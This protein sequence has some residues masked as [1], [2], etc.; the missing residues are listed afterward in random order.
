[1][2]KKLLIFD[3]D[4]TLAD[5]LTTI[6]DAVNMCMEHF[7]Y[8]TLDLVQTRRNVGDG[9]KLLIQ[10]S[11][12]KEAILIDG[13]LDR[14]LEYFRGCYLKTHDNIDD[15]YDGLKEII[16]ELKSKG[17]GLAVLS[18]KP[19][20]LV[21]NI[22]SKLFDEGTFGI[23]MGQTE[24]PKKPEPDV[25]LMIAKQLGYTPDETCFIGDSE[26]DIKTAQNAG[27]TSVAVTWGFRDREELISLNPDVL[28]DTPSQL[29]KFFCGDE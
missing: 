15:C 25:P 1:M 9:V 18:N 7:G 4:G 11:L 27:M 20:H 12:P 10:R 8:P 2:V 13:E 16:Y 14:V 17:Y 29:R 23:S 19:D 21:K 5:T 24:L 22:I 3:L 6:R 26:V 28:I